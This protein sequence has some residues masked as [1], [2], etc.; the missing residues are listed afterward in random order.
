MSKLSLALNGCSLCYLGCM[1]VNINAPFTEY[2]INE[3][4]YFQILLLGI[5]SGTESTIYFQIYID[6]VTTTFY[7]A[8]FW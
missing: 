6:A 4:D 8:I 1:V 5:L 2:R 7:L 3:R